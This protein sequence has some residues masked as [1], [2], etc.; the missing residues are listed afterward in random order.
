MAD[1]AEDERE[2]ELST[3]SAIFPELIVDPA[4][5]FSASLEIPVAPADP[6]KV[7]FPPPVDESVN[8]LPPGAD[9]GA[10]LGIP[11]VHL[12]NFLPSIQLQLE[13][14]KGYPENEPPIVKLTTSLGWLPATTLEQ[15]QEQAA[16]LWD[17][18]GHLQ[19]VFAYIDF[20]QQ[21]AENGFDIE[22]GTLDID[23]DLKIP[24]LD[25]DIKTKRQKFEQETFDCGICLEPKKGSSCYRLKKCCHVFCVDCLQDFYVNAITEGDVANV[26]CLAPDCGVERD[27][28]TK[29][30]KKAARTLSPNELLQIPIERSLVQRY[31]DLKRKK[32]LESSKDTV[33]CPRQ[34]CQG[35]ASVKRRVKKDLSRFDDEES[36]DEAE[37]P[38]I[39]DEKKKAEDKAVAINDRLRICEDCDYAFC[40]VCLTGFLRLH[41]ITY[42]ALSDM[43][44]TE[45]KD[46]WLQPYELLP[47]AWLDPQNP[48]KHFN[49]KKIG[50]YQRLWELEEGDDGNGNVRFEGARGWEAAAAAADEAD[51][52]ERLRE[53]APNDGVIAAVPE[54]PVPPPA[55]V[56]APEPGEIIN[57]AVP[58]LHALRQMDEAQIE[59][60]MN[61]IPEEAAEQL[62]ADIF[63]AAGVPNG[64]PANIQP[65]WR[66]PGLAQREPGR[67]RQHRLP[68]L[69]GGNQFARHAGGDWGARRIND[70]HAARR[71][72]AALGQ[73]N[74]IRQVRGEDW[75]GP[76]EDLGDEGNQE[77]DEVGRDGLAEPGDHVEEPPAFVVLPPRGRVGRNGRG[78][79][80]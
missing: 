29:R 11:D 13:L 53:Q 60:V 18:Y 9:D 74:Y 16:V 77:I 71:E 68:R 42:F 46:A 21:A 23:Q 8:I 72:I 76:Q 4:N 62:I 12:L 69:G 20:I 28:N 27:N 49:D 3:I 63:A 78:R 57:M 15:L 61:N 58:D 36:A 22:D 41:S 55:L 52:A 24:L 7:R 59:E 79:G 32:K 19:V 1:E 54:A 40:R 66:L 67:P 64:L 35:P 31:V 30:A 51:E 25:F 34:W 38:S 10:G 56:P 48:Y 17:E 70:G 2:E 65:G 14:P 39:D 75:I 45:S 26:K 73:Q 37:V 80:R 33:Y 44:F 47:V 6:V 43:F 5:P 50:C